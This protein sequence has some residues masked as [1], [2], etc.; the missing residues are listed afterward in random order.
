MRRAYSG[1]FYLRMYVVEQQLCATIHMPC[2]VNAVE[3]GRL[4]MAERPCEAQGEYVVPLYLAWGSLSALPHVR[5]ARMIAWYVCYE[6][7]TFRMDSCW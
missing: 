4:H 6:D 2:M 7:D 5:Q 1:M 3:R